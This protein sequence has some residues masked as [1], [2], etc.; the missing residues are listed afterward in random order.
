MDSWSFLTRLLE[1]ELLS[2]IVAACKSSGETWSFGARL[3]EAGLPDIAT[4][5][6]KWDVHALGSDFQGNGTKG[7]KVNN[8]KLSMK[9]L[10][11][12]FPYWMYESITVCSD[13]S[14][15]RLVVSLQ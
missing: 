3:I 11:T 9:Y 13:E 14:F 12:M 1:P 15:E 6:R 2:K 10:Y 8:F 5:A 7:R 4:V